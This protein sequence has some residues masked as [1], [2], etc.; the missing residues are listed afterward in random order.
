MAAPEPACMT[1]TKSG[2]NN[3]QR[4]TAKGSRH[5]VGESRFRG[6]DSPAY[7]VL[8]RHGLLNTSYRL[9]TS[10][11]IDAVP[12]NA[13]RP[14]NC[15]LDVL[16]CPAK[17]CFSTFE[18]DAAKLQLVEDGRGS[19]YFYGPGVHRICDPF[20]KLGNQVTYSKGVVKHGDLTLAVVEQGHI[21]FALDQGQPI[22][23]PPGL[24]QWRSPT[25]VFE[26]SYDISNNVIRLGPFTLVTVDSG[27]SHR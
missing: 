17:C 8:S 7:A 5:A 3:K 13:T 10:E 11:Q 22:L 6:E 18:V 21:G 20:Y 24:H 25:M 15:L 19:F 26:K 9:D 2:A 14:V 12:E 16:C 27:Y 4:V 1:R 23:L